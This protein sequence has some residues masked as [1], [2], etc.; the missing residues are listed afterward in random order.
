MNMDVTE[1]DLNAIEPLAIALVG[2]P[3]AGKTTVGRSLARLTN[4]PF[5]DTDQL[6]ESRLGCTIRELF[7]QQGESAFRKIESFTIEELSERGNCVLSTGGGAVL[8]DANRHY[9][10]TKFRCVYLRA[11]P[12]DLFRRLRNDSKRP[13]LQV[14]DPLQTITQLFSVR[15]PLYLQ[16]AKVVVETGRPS[17]G[18]LVE[19]IAKELG[20]YED[21]AKGL[22]AQ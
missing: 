22:H 7:D 2:L 12:Q 5:I 19:R 6:I 21:L 1:D 17:V 4:L 18:A 13:L 10:K 3:G 15:D 14:A 8:E 16:V 11:T 9:L 20:L